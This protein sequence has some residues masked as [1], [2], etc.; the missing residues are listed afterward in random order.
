MKKQKFLEM[1]D[2]C[3]I[4]LTWFITS[5]RTDTK[6]RGSSGCCRSSA[7]CHAGVHVIE[8]TGKTEYTSGWF[9]I[10]VNILKFI[11]RATVILI[12]NRI[13]SGTGRRDRVTSNAASRRRGR[14]VFVHRRDHV[15]VVLLVIFFLVFFV[16][17]SRN[18]R[19]CSIVVLNDGDGGGGG[20]GG[21]GSG[22]EIDDWRLDTRSRVR[23]LD[24]S[25]VVF[26]SQIHISFIAY[27][28]V[29]FWCLEIGINVTKL[30]ADDALGGQAG[31][32][33]TAITTTVTVITTGET[34]TTTITTATTTTALTSST[35]SSSTSTNNSTSTSNSNNSSSV[36]SITSKNNYGRAS[37]ASSAALV[38]F[39]VPVLVP[40]NVLL[41]ILT[42]HEFRGRATRHLPSLP[43]S[44]WLP[45]SSFVAASSVPR[46]RTAHIK[47]LDNTFTDDAFTAALYPRHISS[48][49]TDTLHD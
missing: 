29:I 11:V 8:I 17:R 38:F 42:V 36:T 32:T 35:R 10:L 25:F 3:E 27:I 18:G 47:R 9:T 34:T 20:S 6:S 49:F 15:V 16:T 4:V 19:S 45:T 39:P 30:H 26:R 23:L 46:A 28:F 21:S 44:P 48:P 40:V 33:D 41:L 14:Q 12:Y 43:P 13:N 1:F 24:F 5:K 7:V 2:F 22:G 37:A 31:N